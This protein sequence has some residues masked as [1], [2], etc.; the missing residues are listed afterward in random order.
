M[1]TAD[2]HKGIL[3]I[4][5]LSGSLVCTMS[6]LHTSQNGL[7][8]NRRL[9]PIPIPL[10][11]TSSYHKESTIFYLQ[12]FPLKIGSSALQKLK[13][14]FE[15]PSLLL[16]FTSNTTVLQQTFPTTGSASDGSVTVLKTSQQSWKVCQMLTTSSKFELNFTIGSP[17]L[18]PRNLCLIFK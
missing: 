15:R 13:F 8:W 14:T 11:G 2:I 9:V 6:H 10:A 17:C 12:F 18:H 3:M 4:F 7:G 5:C 1:S 16:S